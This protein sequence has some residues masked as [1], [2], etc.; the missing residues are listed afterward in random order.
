VG[1]VVMSRERASTGTRNGPKPARTDPTQ[2]RRRPATAPRSAHP[3]GEGRDGGR[4]EGGPLS[5]KTAAQRPLC[6]LS[7]DR[8]KTPENGTP[9]PKSCGG[10]PVRSSRLALGSPTEQMIALQLAHAANGIE[11]RFPNVYLTVS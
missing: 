7:W 11:R 3:N 10:R 4:R 9:S 6:P 1:T 8:P 5:V 2:A